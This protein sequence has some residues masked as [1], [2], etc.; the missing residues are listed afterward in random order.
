[1]WAGWLS[2]ASRAG[3]STK[4]LANTG[5]SSAGGASG[6]SISTAT[7]AA[8]RPLSLDFTSGSFNSSFLRE[9]RPSNE[10][11]ASSASQLSLSSSSSLIDAAFFSGAPSDDLSEGESDSFELRGPGSD[12]E[13][14][15]ELDVEVDSSPVTALATPV[16]PARTTPSPRVTA[17]APS[18]RYGS[19]WESLSRLVLALRRVF[20]AF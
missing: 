16:P 13:S 1:M 19:R 5:S 6:S 8:N 12:P 3:N 11:A 17:P 15:A 9:S 2:S 18:Q 20:F 7:A 14:D 10:S 4:A